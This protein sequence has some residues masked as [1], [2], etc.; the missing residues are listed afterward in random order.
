[1]EEYFFNERQI[2]YR[3]NDFNFVKPTMVFI[4]GISGSSSA[5]DLYEKK[6][7]EEYN[8]LSYDLRG[9][10]MSHRY[11]EYNDYSIDN[12]TEDLF[13]L[14][15]YLKIK[16]FIIISHSYGVFTALDFI[17]K[18]QEYIDSSIFL[19]PHYNVNLM[20]SVKIFKPII[21]IANKI[22]FSISDSKQR[23]HID[24]ST[25]INT[26]D[27]NIKRTIEDVSN[28]SL[29]VYLMASKQSFTF[30]YESLLKYIHIPTLIISGENDTIFPTKYAKEMAQKIPNAKID[31]IKNTNHILVLN[32][33]KEV[34]VLLN[35][36]IH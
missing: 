4:H 36:F 29:Q 14:I 35:K 18:H 11:K 1:M 20:L 7:K 30:N 17:S 31:I 13:Q 6:F 22:G 15:K 9:H 19:S 25:Y 34:S 24:Y 21:N 23:K 16:K 32:N 5:W 3:K 8:I 28:T 27:Y 12:F 26:G 2:Y 33:F 10:G